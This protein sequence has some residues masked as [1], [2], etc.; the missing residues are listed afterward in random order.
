MKKIISKAVLS[1]FMFLPI[2]FLNGFIREA[3]YKPHVGYLA[4][5]Q[6]S[7]VTGITAFMILIYIMFRKIVKKANNKEL[8]LAGLLMTIMTVI[9]EFGFGHYIRGFS[10]DYLLADYN[11]FEGRIWILILL[12]EFIGPWIVKAA[13]RKDK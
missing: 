6:I 7:T 3:T 2:A 12:A 10:W 13:I 4:G 8:F 9:F 1:W 11:I 5:H